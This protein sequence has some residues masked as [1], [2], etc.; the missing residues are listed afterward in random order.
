MGKH[1]SYN[2]LITLRL[3]TSTI[4]IFHITKAMNA[5]KLATVTYNV[6]DKFI[7]KHF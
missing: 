1:I 4:T 6:N 2:K 3:S 5:L 7:N